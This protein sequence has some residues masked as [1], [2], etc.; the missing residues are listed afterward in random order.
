MPINF[1]KLKD[2]GSMDVKDIGKLFKQEKS[3]DLNSYYEVNKSENKKKSKEKTK[4]VLSIDF[5]SNS[6]KLAEGKFNKNKLIQIPTSIF[7]V[8]EEVKNINHG[9]YNRIEAGKVIIQENNNGNNFE[10]A[11]DSTVTFGSEFTLSG[12][13]TTF[14]LNIDSNF[15]TVN[16][17]NIKIYKVIKDSSGNSTLTEITNNAIDRNGDNRIKISI[18]DVKDSNQLSDIDILVVYQ[19]RIKESIGSSQVL[20]NEIKFSNISKDVIISTSKVEDIEVI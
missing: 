10:I 11:K 13:S 12:I 18:N 5:G 1:S 8:K 17:D 9:L 15:N 16:T 19:G 20:K 2:I 4:N 7:T 14:E 6:I 3:E